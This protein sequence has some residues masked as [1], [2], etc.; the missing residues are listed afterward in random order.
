MDNATTPMMCKRFCQVW[1]L[2]TRIATWYLV[3]IQVPYRSLAFLPGTLLPGK[4]A[5]T[6]H[7]PLVAI[8]LQSR[9][10]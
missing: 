4:C 7:L 5:V 10:L 1:L 9:Y 8:D 2:T 6:H 3:V